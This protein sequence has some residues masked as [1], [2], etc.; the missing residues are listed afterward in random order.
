MRSEASTV[1][2]YLA[3][4]PEGRREAIAVVRNTIVANLAPGFEEEMNFG[5]VT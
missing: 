3:E 1:E 5:M 2:E 4:L